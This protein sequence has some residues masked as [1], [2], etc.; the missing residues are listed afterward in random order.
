MKTPFFL[1]VQEIR[2]CVA[3]SH[4]RKERGEQSSPLS[5]LILFVSKV[6][7]ID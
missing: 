1:D 3:F 6:A 7:L 4:S 2:K 5:L